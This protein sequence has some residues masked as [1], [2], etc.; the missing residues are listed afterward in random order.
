M[1][2]TFGETPSGVR[3]GGQC[4]PDGES[5]LRAESYALMPQLSTI[6]FVKFLDDLLAVTV[7]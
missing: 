7:P 5:S 3:A 2:G 1:T 4:L 6:F